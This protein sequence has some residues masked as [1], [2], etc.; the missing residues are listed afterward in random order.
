MAPINER[1]TW[2]AE[3]KYGSRIVP[4]CDRCR[5]E[6]KDCVKT[7]TWCQTCRDAHRH[8]TWENVPL[9][10]TERDDRSD[11]V[12]SG[13]DIRVR[14]AESCEGVN[15]SSLRYSGYVRPTKRQRM[16]GSSTGSLKEAD[17]EARNGEF[18]KD[19]NG[20]YSLYSDSAQPIKYRRINDGSVINLDTSDDSRTLP[21]TTAVHNGGLPI[22]GAIRRARHP[23][24]SISLNMESSWLTTNKIGN[25]KPPFSSVKLAATSQG[26]IDDFM[27]SAANE[28]GLVTEEVFH[29]NSPDLFENMELSG[30]PSVFPVSAAVLPNTGSSIQTSQKIEW[31]GTFDF[32]EKGLSATYS[33]PFQIGTMPPGTP[34]GVCVEADFRKKHQGEE[35]YP[36]A[37]RLHTNAYD[38]TNGG[39]SEIL[40]LN[41]RS[42]DRRLMGCSRCGKKILSGRG[43]RGYLTWYITLLYFISDTDC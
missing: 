16:D 12:K 2:V 17:I 18:S 9:R 34:K 8:C 40:A 25:Q 31:S 4:G 11:G 41:S 21:S 10:E 38:Q 3:L 29:S 37:L 19:V 15:E 32:Q 27:E 43:E 24:D 1:P 28:A 39:N 20:S 5:R 6:K 33:P 42:N 26:R 36:S 22:R 35:P 30:P 13:A 23:S 7:T 14:D